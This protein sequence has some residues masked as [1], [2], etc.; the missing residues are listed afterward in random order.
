[1]DYKKDAIYTYWVQYTTKNEEA[2][3]RQFIQGFVA[4]WEPKLNLKWENTEMCLPSVIDPEAGPSLSRLPDELLPAIAKFLYIAKDN[5]EKEEFSKE[6]IV[7]AEYLLRSLIVISRNFYN[8]PLLTS[9]D[10]VGES[11]SVAINIIHKLTSENEQY[12]ESTTLSLLSFCHT[13]CHFLE[14]LYDP[15]QIWRCFDSS[16]MKELDTTKL[17]YSPSMLHVEVVPFIFDC[18]ETNLAVKHPLLAAEILNIFGAVVCG[19]QLFIMLS[20]GEGPCSIVFNDLHNALRGVSPPTCTLIMKV[21][22]DKNVP[23]VVKK[24]ALRCFVTVTQVMIQFPPHQCQLDVSTQIECLTD[25]LKECTTVEI[26]VPLVLCVIKAIGQSIDLSGVNAEK[27]R[28]YVVEC[29]LLEIIL[30]VLSKLETKIE[31]DQVVDCIETISSIL[32]G[33][34]EAKSQMLE[35][36]GYNKVFKFVEKEKKKSQSLL[37]A[38]ISIATENTDKTLDQNLENPQ[39]IVPLIK[40]LPS[41]EEVDQVWLASVIF[42]LCTTNLQSKCH[43]SSCKVIDSVC[44]CL[45]NCDQLVPK[46]VHQL[47]KLI[48]HLASHSI[49]TSELKKIFLLMRDADESYPY[50]TQI[51][52]TLSEIAYSACDYNC[53]VFFDIQ[54][55]N[56]GLRIDELKKWPGPMSGLAFHCWLRLDNVSFHH[57]T[58]SFGLASYRRQLLHLIT[59]SHTGL[60]IFIGSDWTLVV[61]MNTKKEFFTITARDFRFVENRWYCI[62][63]CYS[64][65]KRPFGHNQI[66][67]YIDGVQNICAPAKFTPL[68][69]FQQCSIGTF[70]PQLS[71]SIE[72]YQQT[73]RG[74]L[75]SFITQVPNYLLMRGT[76]AL[77]PYV[78]DFPPGMQDSLY[79]RSMCLKGQ[80]GPICLFPEYLS[81]HQVKTLYE[82]GPNYTSLNTM[83]DSTSDITGMFNRSVFYF[84]P[85]ASS[86]REIALDLS[87]KN[88]VNAQLTSTVYK[89]SSIQDVINMIGGLYVLFPILESKILNESDLGLLSLDQTNMEMTVDIEDFSSLRSYSLDDRLELHP[90]GLLLI[91]MKNLMKGNIVGQEQLLRKNGIPILGELLTNV[92]PDKIDLQMLEALQLF[93]ETLQE[94]SNTQL[95][96]AFYQH[97]L[98]NFTI[99]SRCSFQIQIGVVKLLYLLIKNDRKSFRKRFGVQFFLDSIRT[100]YTTCDVLAA[101]H[102]TVLRSSLLDIV[103]FYVQK[104]VFASDIDIIIRYLITCRSETMIIELLDVLIKY[105]GSDCCKDQV[106]LFIYE[107]QTADLLYSLL[108]EKSISMLAKQHILKLFSV[109]LQTKYVYDRHKCNLR[110]QNSGFGLYPGLISCLPDF[111]NLT[112]EVTLMMLDQIL[113]TDSLSTYT[114]VLSVLHRLAYEE[115]TIKLEAARK[116]LTMIYM[117]P[118]AAKAIAKQAGWQ[119]CV[120][121]LLVHRLA[122]SKTSHNQ[123]LITFKEQDVPKIYKKLKKCR[124]YPNILKAKHLSLRR[125]N[126]MFE[127]ER[128]L[129]NDGF[130]T[131]LTPTVY[132]LAYA[133]NF[134]ENEIKGVAG[135]VSAVVVDNLQYASE[136]LSSAV[137]SVGLVVSDNIQMASDNLAFAMNTVSGNIHSATSN[138][139]SAVTSAYSIFKQKTTEIQE[140]GENAKERLKKYAMYSPQSDRNIIY[141]DKAHSMTKQLLIELGLEADTYSI[142]NRS[143]SSSLEDVSSIKS[144][145]APD[146]RSISSGITSSDN[147]STVCEDI[148]NNEQNDFD[149][150]NPWQEL[151]NNQYDNKEKDLCSFVENILFVVMWRGVNI[152]NKN[153]WKERGQVMAC[154]NMISLNNMLY[155]SHLELKLHILEKA[156]EAVLSDLH[157]SGSTLE[158]DHAKTENVGQLFGLIYD[159]VVLDPSPNF[160]KKCSVKLLDGCIKLIESLAIFG[161]FQEPNS[162]DIAMKFYGILLS[163]SSSSNME[164]CAMA[165]VKLHTILQTSSRSVVE[166]ECYLLRS[167]NTILQKSLKD[168]KLERYSFILPLVKTLITKLSEPLNIS[169]TELPYLTEVL[170]SGQF[171]DKFFTYCTTAEWAVFIETKVSDLCKEYRR[172]MNAEITESM[173]TFWAECYESYKNALD[174]RNRHVADSRKAFQATIVDPYK[175]K[176]QEEESRIY[177][178]ENQRKAQRLLVRAK[179]RQIKGYLCGERGPWKSRTIPERHWILSQHENYSRMRL[180]LCPNYHFDDHKNASNLRDNAGNAVKCIMDCPEIPPSMPQ[181][182]VRSLVEEDGEM[183]PDEDIASYKTN[184]PEEDNERKEKL[185]LSVECQLVTLMSVIKGRL[186]I[187]TTHAYFHDLT[188]ITEDC[189]RH[190]FKWSMTKLRDVYLRRYNLRRSALE[191]FLMDQSNYFLNFTTKTRLK[192]LTVIYN[193]H[194]PSFSYNSSRH[195]QDLL[196]KSGVT[197]KW[198]NREISNFEYLM[199]LN[200]IAGRTYNDLSQYPVFPWVLADYSSEELDLNDPKTFRDLSRPVGVVNP[201]NEADVQAKYKNFEDPNGV[202]GKF[203]YG[204]HYSNSAGVLHYLVRVEPYTS[205]HIDLQSGRF[206]VADRQFHSIAQTWKLL[207]D[208]P[209]DVKELIPEFFYFPEFLKNM[210]NFDLGRLQSSKEK[211]GDVILPPWADNPEDFIYKHRKALESE[212]VSSHL[213]EWIDLIFGYKQKGQ[214]AVDAMNV[215]YYCSYEGAVDLD[216]IVDPVEREAVEGMINNFG[217]TPSQLL[218]EP[219]PQRLPLDK[220]LEKMMKSDNKKPDLTMMLKELSTFYVEITDS[221]H[222]M[223]FLSPPRSGPKGLLQTADDTLV[224]VCENTLIGRHSW[225]PYDR[226]SNKG[227]TLEVDQSHV[228]LKSKKD[229]NAYPTRSSSYHPSIKINS[230]LFAVSNDAKYLFTAGHWDYSVKTFSFSRNKYLSSVIRHFDIVTCIALDTCGWYMISGSRDC[231]SVVWDVS[232]A[233]NVSPKPFQTLLGHDLPVTCV[234]IATELDMAVSGSEDGTVNVY[235]IHQGLLVHCLIPLGCVCPP[236]TISYVTVSFQGHIAF[237]AKDNESHSVHVF[238]CNGDNLGSKYVGAQVT[239]ITTIGDCLVVVDDAGYLTLSRLLGLHPVYDVPLDV[240]VQTVVATPGNT[241]LLAPLRDGNIV[242]IGLPN[243]SN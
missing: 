49:S 28:E 94:I 154:I 223:V 24:T 93:M 136:N 73:D 168:E 174:T 190:D 23:L 17:Q 50:T 97:I 112:M 74:I 159:L 51:L 6:K 175:I 152:H 208:T 143:I 198:V 239:G 204:T 59:S 32:R 46:T 83:D 189:D 186:V 218:R 54:K 165:T 182:A 119:D 114:A 2:S 122:E 240:P 16:Q 111:Q 104:E 26:N 70:I 160:D 217:Q 183:L 45:E 25:A 140:I 131:S 8:I 34:N 7:E 130:R 4:I 11:T 151:T 27:L 195:P 213:H 215:F 148:E 138:L 9:C 219:H 37:K 1:M 205:L 85:T 113:L 193:V 228:L 211:I 13:L 166:I 231:T 71:K 63:V 81:N 86:T 65:P 209:N 18:F 216:A 135:S 76:G 121:R 162:K 10:Y 185:M 212:Y 126:S 201:C 64:P 12:D 144:S 158:C 36:N 75:P 179:W 184:Y 132:N 229:P 129:S 180:K 178:I 117:N 236:S 15:Y 57:C 125:C 197:Q 31:S 84:S 100:Y 108:V 98:F 199:Q 79:G 153:C 19:S 103:R 72:T 120:T 164:I 169:N 60:E 77:D 58:S 69:D 123:D 128:D 62:D 181:V 14:C 20:I 220:A 92:P 35:I 207:M 134:I 124:S 101:N 161:D 176:K 118:N 22:S 242:V 133:A 139:S 234:A 221:K 235:S 42:N 3:F 116:V 222:P 210:N 107:P 149:T 106:F 177:L 41:L 88:K 30:N 171:Y 127:L 102:T 238:S 224:T 68:T 99:W 21:I 233:N 225:L 142:S 47:L 39:M 87:Q 156:V 200:T 55:D 206:D 243:S 191:F 157:D 155:C 141:E 33:S 187:T 53:K 137:N 95:L 29:K 109:L 44:K 40:W 48:E 43:S 145:I 115:I 80:L 56:D 241:H 232:N 237:S 170:Y 96:R 91:L 52:G 66:S 67:I 5:A 194:P 226:H 150:I 78:K 90:I 147:I 188:P 38:I 203:H 163:C 61:G 192:V 230:H 214:A 89:C 172:S 146:N 110:L 227:F 196:R 202:I 105:L 82:L 173:N 167:V